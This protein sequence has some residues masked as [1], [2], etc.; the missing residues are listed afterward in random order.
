V[1][2]SL[3]T[4]GSHSPSLGFD[5]HGWVFALHNISIWHGQGPTDGHPSILSPYRE[6]VGGLVA[7][8][9]V[10]CSVC[11]YDITVGKVNVNS[12]G[13]IPTDQNT[14][15]NTPNLDKGLLYRT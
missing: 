14:T 13:Y 9:H 1:S 8:L 2:L 10:L 12:G 15:S 7:S 6:E 3:A 4:D 5:S 11:T